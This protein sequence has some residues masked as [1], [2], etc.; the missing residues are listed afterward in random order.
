VGERC[1]ILVSSGLKKSW[2]TAEESFMQDLSRLV[3]KHAG[4][5]ENVAALPELKL[6]AATP[7]LNA[8]ISFL[9]VCNICAL[10]QNRSVR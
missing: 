3:K 5:T 8:C 1:G 4:Q 7:A 2:F 9:E 6:T 10:Y